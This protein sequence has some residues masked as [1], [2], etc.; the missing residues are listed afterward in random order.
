MKVGSNVAISS[1]STAGGGKISIMQATIDG[2]LSL[3]PK[4]LGQDDKGW[5]STGPERRSRS[6]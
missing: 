1:E 5:H 2:N 3:K 4:S 6:G